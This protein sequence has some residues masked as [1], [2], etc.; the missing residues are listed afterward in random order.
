MTHET[1]PRVR[2]FAP[3]ESA[4]APAAR[5]GKGRAT[6][7]AMPAAFLGGAAGR[8]LPASIPFRYFGAAVVFHLLAWIALFAG[9]GGAARFRGGLG[10]PLASLHLVTLGVLV[11][12]ALGA[13]L[14]LFPVATRQPVAG[15]LVPGAIWWLYTPGV[16]VLALGMGVASP[17]LL[18]AGALCVSVALVL[19]AAVLARNLFGARGMPA[20]VA[21]GWVAWVALF[22]ALVAALSLIFAYAGAPAFARD[23]ALALHVPFAA[24]GFVGMLALGLSY[25]LV[26]MFALS[27]APDVRRALASCVLGAVA[28]VLVAAAAFGTGAA[29]LRLAAIAAGAAAVALHLRLMQSALRS[30][31]RRDRGPAF[32]LVRLGWAFLALS[33]ALAAGLVAGAPFEALATLTGFALVVGWLLTFLLGILQRIVPFLA[34]MHAARGRH[35]PPTPSALAAGPA[36]RIHFACHLAALGL[37]TLGIVGDNTWL[38]RLAAIAGT[39]GAGAFAIFFA[40]VIRRMAGTSVR[41]AGRVTTA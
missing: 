28:L 10:W 13:S 19:Y 26:P 41:V 38:V 18:G 22:V 32:R 5:A 8:L 11:M 30:G 39:A 4:G 24:Y 6:A 9:A 25:I 34:S 7:R 12:T 23:A 17:M 21:H 27:P 16:A 37:L 15:R 40:N 31:M 29:A 1:G 36:L 3:R 14:Q 35:L 20:V 2:S 33:L